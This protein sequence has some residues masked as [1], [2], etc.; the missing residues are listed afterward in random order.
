MLFAVVIS[1][2]LGIYAARPPEPAR[3]CDRHGFHP[4][5]TGDAEFWLG[6]LL[7][8]LFAVKLN[9]FCRRGISGLERRCL[10]LLQGPAAAAFA[11]GVIRAAI[12]TRL[13]RSSMLEVIARGLCAHRQAKGLRNAPSSMSM[14][15][16]T[17]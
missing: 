8:L 15:C 5:R 7:I 6:I 4:A 11:L 17:R 2:P 1:I 10:G 12:L 9:W 13:T 16:A 3:G 14:R